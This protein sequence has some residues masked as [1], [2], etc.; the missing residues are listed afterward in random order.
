[1]SSYVDLQWKYC[2]LVI[3]RE[4]DL[5][6]IATHF[7]IDYSPDI[8]ISPILE[9]LILDHLGSEVVLHSSSISVLNKNLQTL[10]ELE[11]IKLQSLILESQSREKDRLEKEKD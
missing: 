1:M 2:H 4:N 9:Q 11:K 6:Y 8:S 5:K 7:K 3:P 10:L